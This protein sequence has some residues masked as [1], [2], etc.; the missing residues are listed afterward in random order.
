[1]PLVGPKGTHLPVP[2]AGRPNSPN[3]SFRAVANAVNG[4]GPLSPPSIE[5]SIQSWSAQLVGLPSGLSLMVALISAE[6]VAHL[7]IFLANAEGTWPR[8]SLSALTA[9]R[10]RIDFSEVKKIVVATSNA[11]MTPPVLAN[12]ILSLGLVIRLTKW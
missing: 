4:G 11:A 5:C 1:M 2:N 6:N 3:Q 10:S 7:A 12:V 9:D 8:L